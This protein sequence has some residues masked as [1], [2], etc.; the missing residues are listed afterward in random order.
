MTKPTRPRGAAGS[1]VPGSATRLLPTIGTFQPHAPAIHGGVCLLAP[2]RLLPDLTGG[3][4]APGR[5]DPP[6]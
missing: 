3:G 2:K 4:T 1:R 5:A 6:V